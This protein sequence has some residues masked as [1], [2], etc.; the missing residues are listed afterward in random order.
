MKT[1]F[2]LLSL[3]AVGFLMAFF[4]A[5]ASLESEAWDAAPFW[6]VTLPALALAAGV[7]GYVE[8]RYFPAWGVPLVAGLW[9]GMLIVEKPGSLWFVGVILSIPVLGVCT[10]AAALGAALQRRTS[11]RTDRSF[12]SSNERSAS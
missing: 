7:A 10:L 9:V 11:A 6:W 3:V 12:P 5:S 2:I 4:T 8:P 1:S